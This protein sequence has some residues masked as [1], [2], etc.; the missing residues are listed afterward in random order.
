MKELGKRLKLVTGF[1]EILP[2]Y[3][4]VLS[5]RLRG[6]YIF[7]SGKS[8]IQKTLR[9]AKKSGFNPTDGQRAFIDTTDAPAA[10]AIRLALGD[11]DALEELLESDSNLDPPTKS[12]ITLIR[13]TELYRASLETLR[14]QMRA[15]E[16]EARALLLRGFLLILTGRANEEDTDEA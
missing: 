10:Q 4:H 7:F 3:L 5:N 15:S 1:A 14:D 9:Q 16:K 13:R 12:A 8:V 11:H 6:E 2:D